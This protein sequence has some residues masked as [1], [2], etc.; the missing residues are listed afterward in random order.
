MAKQASK[1]GTEKLNNS[2]P[3]PL[4]LILAHENIMRQCRPI[5]TMS[6]Y[7]VLGA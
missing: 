2:T 7:V 1:K 3:M 4:E 5:V 6:R